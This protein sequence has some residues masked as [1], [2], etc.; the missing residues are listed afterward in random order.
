MRRVGGSAHRRRDGNTRSSPAVQ[1]NLLMLMAGSCAIPPL[2]HELVD[3]RCDRNP[4][5]ARSTS[6][7]Q[8]SARA[9][10]EGV[11]AAPRAAVLSPLSAFA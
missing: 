11:E 6:Q 3:N 5:S 4:L 2:G 9:L 7:G 8:D 1:P 10:R